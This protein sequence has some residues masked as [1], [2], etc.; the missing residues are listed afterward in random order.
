MVVVAVLAWAKPTVPMFVGAGV[1]ALTTAALMFRDFSDS[2][3]GALWLPV[4][5]LALLF[6][7]LAWSARGK[8]RQGTRKYLALLGI[9]AACSVAIVLAH[10]VTVVDL[11]RAAKDLPSA[12]VFLVALA[13][14]LLCSSQRRE[15]LS[16]LAAA[17]VALL[18][19]SIASTSFL[20]R[21]GSDPFLAEPHPLRWVELDTR[22]I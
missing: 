16:G 14:G 21:F 9:A 20:D 22:P 13:G 17:I 12:T 7:G 18:L 11:H 8:T 15:Q 4:L 6:F 3:V 2:Y 5:V 19:V 1:A 10:G